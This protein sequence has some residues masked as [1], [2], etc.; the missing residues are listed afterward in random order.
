MLQQT[1]INQTLI[2][3]KYLVKIKTLFLI[4]LYI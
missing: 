1:L 2:D 4:N 3:A